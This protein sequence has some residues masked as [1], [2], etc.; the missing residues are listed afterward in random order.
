MSLSVPVLCGTPLLGRPASSSPCCWLCSCGNTQQWC[1]LNTA[2]ENSTEVHVCFTGVWE[3]TPL[4]KLR[5]TVL[6]SDHY[7]T[8]VH[9]LTSKS[10][11]NVFALKYHMFHFTSKSPLSQGQKRSMS[12]YHLRSAL[13]LH[14]L[15][16]L[17]WICKMCQS[18]LLKELSASSAHGQEMLQLLG[19][20][21]V[22][23]QIGT[24]SCYS[25]SF[26]HYPSL[27]YSNNF[28]VTTSMS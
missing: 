1:S 4:V 3:E 12:R 25:I 18:T 20:I 6:C 28:F 23:E 7:H 24:R 10:K 14:P 16:M 21:L 2:R 11:D 13:N 27:F 5:S 22:L 9:A 17:L 8:D 26:F 15:H 19:V